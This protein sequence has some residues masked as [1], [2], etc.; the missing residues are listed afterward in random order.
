MR[1]YARRDSRKADAALA[2]NQNIENNPMESSMMI[3]G[4]DALSDPARTF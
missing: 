4:I 1:R 2:S 3:A